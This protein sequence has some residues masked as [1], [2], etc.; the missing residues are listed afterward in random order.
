MHKFPKQ[1][2]YLVF[3]VLIF[4]TIGPPTVFGQQRPLKVGLALSGGGARGAS[5][6]GVLKVL[7]RE[8]IPIDYIAGTSF[9]AL[10][11]GFYALGYSAAEIEQIFFGQDWNEIFSDAPERRLEPLFERK[12]A[13][14]Q[15]NLS[16]RGW[17]P[18]LPTGLWEGQRLRETLNELTT[19]QMLAA[20]YDFDKLPIPFRAVATN[21]IDGKAYIFQRGRMSEALRASIA[22]PMLFTPVEKDGMLLADGGLL[23]NLPTDI[24]RNMGADIVIAVDVTSPLKDKD[25]I[26]TF[27][28]VMDQSI[29]LSMRYSVEENRKLANLLL[30]P[31]LEDYNYSDFTKMPEIMKLGEEEAEK[32]LADVKALVAGIP[33]RLYQSIATEKPIMIIDVVSFQGL[34]NVTPRQMRREIKLH[35][36]EAVDLSMLT[37]NLR[38]LFATQLFKSVDYEL[39]NIGENKYLLTYIL[40]EAPL[41]TLGSSIRYDNDYQ[42][43]ALAE[44]TARQ[45]FNTSTS[46]TLSTQFGGLE[47]HSAALRFTPA[48]LPFF[49]IEPKVQAWKRERQ[50]IRDEQLVD[51]YTDNRL[52]GQLLLGSYFFRQL[53][54]SAGY[55]FERASISG[56]TFPNS[57]EEEDSLG[58]LTLRFH[59]DS[60]DHPEFARSGVELNFQVDKLS[61]SLGGDL[62]YSKYQFDYERYLTISN[63][64]TLQV[65]VA[66]GY[67]RGSVPFYDRFY[68]G[69]YTFSEGGSRHLLGFKTDELIA[70]QMA[71]LGASYRRLIYNQPLGF[72][73]RAYL[74]G[75]YNAVYFSERLQSPYQFNLLN[76]AGIGLA[77]DTMIGPI[78]I[79]G[80]WGEGGRFNFHLSVGPAY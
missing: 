26:Q 56:G 57:Q 66:A 37:E 73:K 13:R 21:L 52:G 4:L 69:G 77:L 60:L 30:E 9:G 42:F 79:T 48:A 64:S 5:H 58:G 6:V 22:I 7:E 27:L 1:L 78:R 39:E 68:L 44:L 55:R 8:H 53:E 43:V 28:D 14:Y 36:G 45:L 33:P 19:K 18:D 38:R 20:Q 40:K 54:I 67:S 35:L 50:D 71:I 59:R 16:F 31:D 3:G 2:I 74:K 32:R 47:N 29:S 76:G 72:V 63:K 46:L 10:V 23:N 24:V 49:F 11:G 17:I 65:N 80:G 61:E 15:V 70:A 25:E 12:N 51:K 75:F 34:K 62:N 41:N